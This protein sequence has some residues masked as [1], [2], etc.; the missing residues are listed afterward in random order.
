VVLVRLKTLQKATSAPSGL[1]RLIEGNQNRTWMAIEL[2]Q[3]SDA[4]KLGREI[5]SFIGN[6]LKPVTMILCK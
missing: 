1:R 5:K 4:D 2:E 3:L 6:E